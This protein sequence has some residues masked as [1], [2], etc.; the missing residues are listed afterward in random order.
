MTQRLEGDPLLVAP[1]NAD[2]VISLL[3]FYES[4]QSYFA[5]RFSVPETVTIGRELGVIGEEKGN[6]LTC[7]TAAAPPLVALSFDPGMLIPQPARTLDLSTC[8]DL[9]GIQARGKKISLPRVDKAAPV[10]TER[11]QAAPPEEGE[12]DGEVLLTETP[13]DSQNQE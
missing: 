11:S 1:F 3:Y 9:M 5:K 6:A 2:T 13:D 4:K 7:A 8:A 10:Y 12:A